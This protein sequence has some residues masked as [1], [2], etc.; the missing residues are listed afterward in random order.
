[1]KIVKIMIPRLSDHYKLY[2]YR[3]TS[4]DDINT[5]TKL[6]DKE[7]V[8]IIDEA[9]TPTETLA[10][11]KDYYIV[12]DKSG[13]P[14]PDG[15]VFNGPAA[16][17][18]PTVEYETQVAIEKINDYTYVNV[19]QLNPLE[20]DY[21]GT[22]LYYNVIGV[23]EATN[24]MT[25]LSK[26]A[27]VLVDNDYKDSDS[28]RRILCCND[29]TGEDTDVWEYVG[30]ASWDETIMIGNVNDSFMFTRYGNPFVE[31]VPVIDTSKV[32]AVLKPIIPRR[33]M[34][35]EIPNPWQKNNK[36]FNFR[37]LKSYKIQNIVGEQYGGFSEPSYQSVLPVSIEQ[38][39][40]LRKNDPDN[41]DE[42]IPYDEPG[43]EVITYKIIRKDGIFYNKSD[44]IGLSLNKYNIP[45][46]EK[47]AIFSE[48]SVQDFIK[49][50]MYAGIGH[51]Y[52]FTMYLIDVYN[53]VSEPMHFVITT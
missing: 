2:V 30:T 9:V 40:I 10:D 31:T 53:N 49:I 5:I 26:M 15:V 47:V 18:V 34:I 52:S 6:A 29:Y 39:L 33:Y 1:M 8:F 7:P 28:S 36:D 44:Y 43:D 3:S 42:I 46:E 13:Y 21:K 24:F 38:L 22:V 32:N 45:V 25:H 35:L 20:I 51:K 27:G 4:T 19:L 37:K 23:D 14:Q 11:G 17:T 41:V 12:Y 50:Q 16:N 48:A